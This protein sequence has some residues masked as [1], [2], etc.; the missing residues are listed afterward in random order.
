MRTSKVGLSTKL[1]F[2]LILSLVLLLGGASAYA[3]PFNSI[4]YHRQ[5]G[6]FWA[7]LADDSGPSPTPRELAVTSIQNNFKAIHALKFDTVTI[8][9]P[10]S[11]NRVSEHGGGFSYDPKNPAAARPK[12]PRNWHCCN[13]DLQLTN[14]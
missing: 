7:Q 12:L 6:S 2:T 8:G 11:D 3:A 14:A 4:Y 13:R 5:Q 10:D 1:Q 9:L